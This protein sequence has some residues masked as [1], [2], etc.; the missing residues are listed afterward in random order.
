MRLIVFKPKSIHKNS[1]Y[2]DYPMVNRDRILFISN[3]EDMNKLN[4]ISN[5]SKYIVYVSV[6]FRQCI[7]LIK[8]LK[9]NGLKVFNYNTDTM[10]LTISNYN[11][12][13][14]HAIEERRLNKVYTEAI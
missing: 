13:D 10:F 14:A 5:K 3:E 11:K 2:I 12:D 7:D 4:G 8:H 6:P 9:S 1:F